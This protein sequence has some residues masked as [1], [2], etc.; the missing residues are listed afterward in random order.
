MVSQ[1]T[2][3]MWKELL[4]GIPD[5]IALD[6]IAAKL[7]ASDV[8]TLSL[9]SERWRQETTERVV[10]DTRVRYHST[11]GHVVFR[12]RADGLDGLQLYS[13]RNKTVRLLP[14]VKLPGAYQF[15]TLDGKI[16]ALGGEDITREDL[17]LQ[18]GRV[19]VLDLVGQKMWKQCASMLQPRKEFGLGAIGGKIYVFGG[20]SVNC[21]HDPNCAAEV[22]DPKVDAWYPINR[23]TLAKNVW[24]VVTPVG[25]ELY[26]HDQ[27][28]CSVEIYNPCTNK[29]RVAEPIILKES[30]NSSEFKEISMGG[31]QMALQSTT[32]K[33]NCGHIAVQYLVM[34]LDRLILSASTQFSCYL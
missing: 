2:S 29:W 32:L 24:D 14:R 18:S 13:L 25:E 9:L 16:Y 31:I 27:S 6:E 33:Q 3:S 4:P 15:I 17:Q 23:P 5:D 22:Y 10:Y 19:L 20:K 11:E 30:C 12:G 1:E 21:G 28:G 34:N 8:A 26:V 7:P